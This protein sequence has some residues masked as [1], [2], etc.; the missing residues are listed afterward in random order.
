MKIGL[1]KAVVLA[2]RLNLFFGLRWAAI[3]EHFAGQREMPR[4]DVVVGC[5]D[6]RRARAAIHC[7]GGTL[8]T[9]RGDPGEHS[10]RLDV[11]CLVYLR[12]ELNGRQ[13]LGTPRAKGGA[14]HR[15]LSR[16]FRLHSPTAACH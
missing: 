8:R 16:D 11:Q 4:V 15:R 10:T 3:P 1:T 7:G 13:D 2:T 9:R 14:N 5:V 12:D 6:T